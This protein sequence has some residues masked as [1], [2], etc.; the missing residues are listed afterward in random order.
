MRVLCYGDSNTYGFDPRSY[1]GSRYPCEHRWVDLLAEITGW[2]TVN[3][4]ENGREIPRWEDGFQ[5]VSVLLSEWK[6]DILLV[7]LGG[8][9]L[10]QGAGAADAAKRMERFLERIPLQKGKVLLI[11]PPP[12]ITGAWVTEARLTEDSK[13][14]SAAYRLLAERLGIYF[15]DAGEWGIGLTFDGVHFS[16][17][18]HHTFAERL[19]AVL[20]TDLQN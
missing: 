6:P 11:S 4:G 18:G 7:M 1:I 3:A 14:L 2:E 5:S 16:E 13:E 12:M 8:N 15:A 20:K 10:L 9:D 17:Q 19:A